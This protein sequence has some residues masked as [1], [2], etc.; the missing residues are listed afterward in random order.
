MGQPPVGAAGQAPRGLV[1]QAL[2]G[3]KA[4]FAFGPDKLLAALLALQRHIRKVHGSDLLLCLS[5]LATDRVAPGA[6]HYGEIK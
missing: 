1:D 3:V 6:A 4:L 5:W 2:L